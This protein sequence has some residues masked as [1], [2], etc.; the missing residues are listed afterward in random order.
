M[1]EEFSVGI[2]TVATPAAALVAT[3]GGFALAASVV[4]EGLMLSATAAAELAR[5]AGEKGMEA[6]AASRARLDAVANDARLA[7]V[8]AALGAEGMAA[9]A[10]ARSSLPAGVD[11][12][13]ASAPLAQAERALETAFTR[14]R[15]AEPVAVLSAAQSALADC[16]FKVAAAT[17]V[18]GGGSR[19]TG[20]KSG[21]TVVLELDHQGGTLRGDVGGFSGVSCRAELTALNKALVARGLNLGLRVARL[22]G[23][24]RGGVM[25]RAAEREADVRT[26]Q[27]PL[28]RTRGR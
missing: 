6:T 13:A 9:V 18:R 8:R 21:R 20:R 5:V 19:V 3:V 17:R 11:R 24:P 12:A 27:A 10:S 1:S 4:G 25:L 7:L 2:D 22:H 14:L 16:G 28:V 15:A 26:V 23:D